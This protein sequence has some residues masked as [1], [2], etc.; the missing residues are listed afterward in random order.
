MQPTC[1]A[2][3]WSGRVIVPAFAEAGHFAVNLCPT[4]QNV[5]MLPQRT[6]NLG[7]TTRVAVRM[8]GW[9]VRAQAMASGEKRRSIVETDRA[10][11]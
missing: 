4:L 5:F 9:Q 2:W 8:V 11:G 6:P 1:R 3:A 10:G 7:E